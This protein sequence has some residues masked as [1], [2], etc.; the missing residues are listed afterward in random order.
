[1]GSIVDKFMSE[2]GAQLADKNVTIEVTDGRAHVPRREGLR[3]RE[4]RAPAR[5]RHPGRGE[6][7]LGDELLFGEL[8]HGGTAS[9]V[10][11]ERRRASTFSFSLDRA[12]RRTVRAEAPHRSVE[13]VRHRQLELRDLGVE[14]ALPSAR[15]IW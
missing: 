8:E 12:P 11:V 10:D 4:R 9:I 7:P 5:A 13:R 3:S 14:R 15:C 1:M 2:L 6:A